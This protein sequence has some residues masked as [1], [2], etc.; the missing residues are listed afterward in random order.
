MAV[1][2]VQL[3]EV[4][5]VEQQQ[6]EHVAPAVPGAHSL[7]Q[8][9]VELAPVRQAG[10]RIGQRARN[11]GLDFDGLFLQAAFGRVQLR[12]QILIRANDIA[13]HV[14]DQLG[15]RLVASCRCPT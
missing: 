9:L 3:L 14:D 11:V 7:F 15:Q 10:E 12:F 1:P 2:I 5:H 4:I 13:D 6:R 8:P